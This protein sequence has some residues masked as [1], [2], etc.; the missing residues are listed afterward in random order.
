MSIIDHI[1]LHEANKFNKVD[2]PNEEVCILDDY[3]QYQDK[4]IREQLAE[5]SPHR[6]QVESYSED[7]CDNEFLCL[8]EVFQDNLNTNTPPK[9]N[10]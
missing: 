3:R 8:D 10:N 7:K 4:L 2:K 1:R 5:Y 9:K 6:E